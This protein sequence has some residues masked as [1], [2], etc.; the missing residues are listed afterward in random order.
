MST[1]RGFRASIVTIYIYIHYIYEKLSVSI[2]YRYFFLVK[3][4]N[5][6]N[7]DERTVPAFFRKPNGGRI[8]GG[9]FGT[10]G[11]TASRR[12]E[13][14]EG[15]ASEFHGCANKGVVEYCKGKFWMS[16]IRCRVYFFQKTIM[17]ERPIATALGTVNKGWRTW[18]FQLFAIVWTEIAV[19][20]CSTTKPVKVV[21]IKD[22]SFSLTTGTGK[23]L[24][25]YGTDGRGYF[26]LY[27][28]NYS[29]AIVFSWHICILI[30]WQIKI[31]MLCRLTCFCYSG[32]F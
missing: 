17:W 24:V 13:D 21:I 9:F 18:Q 15:F 23:A 30:Y 27:D 7:D 22:I 31:K 10:F 14:L 19:S 5:R 1:G 20:S 25:T 2:H 8:D 16:S 3:F 6:L 32:I 12:E 26:D 28:N 4:L 29:L 11:S